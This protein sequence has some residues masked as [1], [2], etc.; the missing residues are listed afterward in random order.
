MSELK[1][2]MLSGGSK[3]STY[4][5]NG[6]NGNFTISKVVEEEGV[7]K[8]TFL[9]RRVKKLG[10]LKVFGQVIFQLSIPKI[11]E[12]IS[13]KRIKEIISSYQLEEQPI[14]HNTIKK[15]TSI[16]SEESI[17]FIKSEKPDLIIVNGTRIISKKV[18]NCTNAI[19]I[20]THA[21]ITPKYRGVHGGY[22]AV[23]NDDKANCGVTVHLV[24][25]GIDTGGVLFQQII[26][27]NPKDNFVTYTYLQIGEGI[28]LMK[29]AISDFGKGN[30]KEKASLT[31][32]S[33]L[34][35]HPTIWYYLK[36][37]I[38]NGVK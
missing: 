24:D 6:L 17:E 23:A 38:F 31:Q 28:N 36:K 32:E 12:A 30:L 16:N 37:W 11:L 19:F 4:M 29:K 33:H 13:K 18:L 10:R 14:P 5:F 20:N 25:S 27:P 7:D 3:S 9:K 2:I 1:I 22:W 34:W 35:H 8:I 21:G 26:Q 15:V